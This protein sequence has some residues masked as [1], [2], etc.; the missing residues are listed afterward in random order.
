MEHKKQY[1]LK[2]GPILE[3]ALMKSIEDFASDRNTKLLNVLY[4]MVQSYKN[5]FDFPHL[6]VPFHCLFIILGMCR[7]SKEFEGH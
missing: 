3:D 5:A 1:A 4:L 6:I 2:F 7:E